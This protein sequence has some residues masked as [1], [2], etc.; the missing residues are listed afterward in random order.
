MED[1]RHL[2]DDQL[3]KFSKAQKKVALFLLDNSSRIKEFEISDIVDQ[4]GVSRSSIIRF[5]KELG[6]GGYRDLKQYITS[7]G[8]S[9]S[10]NPVVD[11]ITDSMESVIQQTI[12]SLS[13]SDLNEAI[14]RCSNATRV[15]WYGVGE[16]GLL[17]EM[18]N[19][20]CWL[21][22]IESGFCREM[23]QFTDFRH[24]IGPGE[25][26]IVISLR[27]D[28]DYLYETLEGLREKGVFIIGLTS[29]RLSWLAKNASLCLF[30]ISRGATIETRH[31]PIRAGYELAYNALILGIAH[32]R[33]IAFKLEENYATSQG[34]GVKAKQLSQTLAE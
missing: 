17:A 31:V 5:F 2:L 25:V 6:F 19:Y 29:N 3:H 27:G 11:W 4:T 14:E 33:G 10:N 28:G 13:Y 7:S 20:R 21:M 12:G 32:Q 34:G 16:S 26:L 30:P 15:F 9:I 8:E 22:G 18:A 23:S 24:R 1:L